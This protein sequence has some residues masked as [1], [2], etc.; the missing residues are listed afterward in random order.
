MNNVDSV[1]LKFAESMDLPLH[2][3][4]HPLVLVI[5]EL[6]EDFNKYVEEA[7]GKG[8]LPP[9]SILGFY[10]PV[11]NWLVVRMSSCDSF[12]VPLHEAIHQQVANRIL[13]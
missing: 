4:R 7:T 3:P 11:T 1:F 13:Q 8:G 9:E 12:E 2:E 10:W 5:F 6:D